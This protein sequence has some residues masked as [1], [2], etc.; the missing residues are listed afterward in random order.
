[1]EIQTL[2]RKQSRDRPKRNPIRQRIAIL[3]ATN[4]YTNE[5]F[6]QEEED[7]RSRRKDVLDFMEWR[8]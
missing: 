5:E 7:F 8:D 2:L 1:M 6:E 3:K 4:P